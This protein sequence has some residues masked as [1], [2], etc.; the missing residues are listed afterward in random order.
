MTYVD[1]IKTGELAGYKT[2]APSKEAAQIDREVCAESI[3]PT[4][5]HQGL[6][7]HPW[8]K[9][10]SYRAFATCPNCGHFDEF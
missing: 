10:G 1:F 3:C 9:P 2:G 7:Y 5:G 8:H 6:T 4:C